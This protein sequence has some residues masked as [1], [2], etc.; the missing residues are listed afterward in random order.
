MLVCPRLLCAKLT[1][2]LQGKVDLLRAEF[3]EA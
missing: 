2:L 3:D 1:F